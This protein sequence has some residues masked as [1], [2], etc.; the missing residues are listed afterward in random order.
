MVYQSMSAYSL[1]CELQVVFQICMVAY[2]VLHL[3]SLI[4]LFLLAR[5]NKAYNPT[6][7]KQ[8]TLNN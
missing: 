2:E 4:Y 5:A 7:P 6:T 3:F 1:V 8:D